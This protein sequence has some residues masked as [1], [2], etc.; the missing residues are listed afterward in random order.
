MQVHFVAEYI[1]THAHNSH[2]EQQRL[3]D[4]VQPNPCITTESSSVATTVETF[5]LD[6]KVA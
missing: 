1:V 2:T 4:L 6:A 3:T 5:G